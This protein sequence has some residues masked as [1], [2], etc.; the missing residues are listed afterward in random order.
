MAL[1]ASDS[2]HAQTK[3]ASA[4]SEFEKQKLLV[5]LK[6]AYSCNPY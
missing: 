6:V 4:E 3:L 1:T 2:A 5:S